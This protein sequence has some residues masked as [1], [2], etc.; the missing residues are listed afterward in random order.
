[1][2]RLLGHSAAAVVVAFG[3]T[4]ASS[5][6]AAQWIKYPT[7]GVPRKADGMVDPSA[8]RTT[9][10]PSRPPRSSLPASATITIWETIAV[11]AERESALWAAAL[12]PAVEREE[13]AVFS[14]LADDRFG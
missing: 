9:S 13:V 12:R 4:C 10:E 6:S 8:P 7:A 14:P 5:L 11:E 1:M 3:L 2:H